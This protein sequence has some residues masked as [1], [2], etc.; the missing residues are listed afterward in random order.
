MQKSK[1]GKFSIFSSLDAKL[2]FLTGRVELIQFS[3]GSNRVKLKI[4]SIQLESNWKCEQLDSSMIRIQN[5]NSKLDSTISLTMSNEWV[6]SLS[7]TF[8][9]QIILRISRFSW[10]LALS[11]TSLLM[12][13]FWLLVSIVM[14]I[15]CASTV[16]IRR[17]ICIK[18]MISFA[19]VWDLFRFA[20]VSELTA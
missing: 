15:S 13:T 1:I 2:E 17:I 9:S 10:S 18:F 12:I 11:F 16:K 3:V 20:W 7:T 4:C 19:H 6:F 5:V 8:L 14:C